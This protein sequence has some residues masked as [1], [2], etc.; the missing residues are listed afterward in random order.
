[1][2]GAPLCPIC[3][4]ELNELARSVPYAHHTKSFMEEDPV[5][6]PNGRVMG[7][8]RLRALNEKMGVRRGR[9]RDPGEGL[10][11]EEWEEGVL[12]KVFIS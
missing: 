11:G 9:V 8:E 5:V 1:M 6:L 4:S 7:R 12:R 10:E 2:L 3:S